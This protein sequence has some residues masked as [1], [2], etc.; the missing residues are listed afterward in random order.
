VKRFI[1][2]WTIFSLILVLIAVIGLIACI[3][4]G[5]SWYYC[6]AI[7]GFELIF[8]LVMFNFFIASSTKF[9]MYL[10]NLIST[11]FEATNRFNGRKYYFFDDILNAVDE[12]IKKVRSIKREMIM[13]SEQSAYVSDLLSDSAKE[14]GSS[15]D[16]I[17][18]SIQRLALDAENLTLLSKDSKNQL[19]ELQ[20]LSEDTM[21]RANKTG[22][23][24]KELTNIIND[25]SNT[26]Q[27]LMESIHLT[28]QQSES[29]KQ[30]MAELKQKS[31]QITDITF[32][33]EQVADQT[34]L[35]ALNAAIEA[36]RAGEYGRGFAVV[37]H[38]VRKLAEETK[39]LA[40]DIG[41]ILS[42]IVDA[43][44]KN[45]QGAEVSYEQSNKAV[46]QAR[47][48]ISI[49]GDVI[50]SAKDLEIEIGEIKKNNI[51]QA[52]ESTK[53]DEA[54][55]NIV[56]L[57][58]NASATSQEVS[59]AGQEQR[60]VLDELLSTSTYLSYTKERLDELN[61]DLGCF[62]ELEENQREKLQ[63]LL[64][65]LQEEASS[66]DLISMDKER[67]KLSFDRI[68]NQNPIFSM[69]C[70][71]DKQGII[72]EV[73]KPIDMQNL[74]FRPWFREAVRGNTFISDP[75][76]AVGTD[77]KCVTLSVPIFSEGDVVGILA[78]DVNYKDV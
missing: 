15:Y 73:S 31:I 65:Y 58:E 50:K 12:Y 29:L 60:A 47:E 10:R 40:K 48:S 20:K 53:V 21:A 67:H 39:V 72:C 26:I 19:T 5:W 1:A 52:K 25:S 13:V 38:E 42:E 69:L 32:S 37:A 56:N 17:L 33:V 55:E 45:I 8:F 30:N 57:I 49:I 78:G 41:N 77:E 46:E 2:S 68:L 11:G 70:T 76:L 75:Y 18:E 9:K 64:E 43:V 22:E 51:S 24:F 74:A 44:E 66:E 7:I 59:A 28:A 23:G 14:V 6:I 16:Q 35:L 34:N 36:A 3:W 63:G 4:F 54:F 62:S 27:M 61:E 71:T